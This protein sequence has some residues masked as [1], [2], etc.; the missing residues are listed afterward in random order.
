MT[1]TKYF[2]KKK[3]GYNLRILRVNKK[4]LLLENFLNLLNQILKHSTLGYI[5]CFLNNY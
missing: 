5:I 4:I 2:F 3:L 1:I